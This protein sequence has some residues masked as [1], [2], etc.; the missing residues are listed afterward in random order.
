MEMAAPRRARLNKPGPVE[1][2][3]LIHQIFVLRI[4]ATELERTSNHAMM[5]TSSV[6]TDVATSAG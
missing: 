5:E 6:V 4:A 3:P 2:A 1:A